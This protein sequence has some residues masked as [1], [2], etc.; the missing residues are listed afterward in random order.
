MGSA[1]RE[2]KPLA[3]GQIVYEKITFPAKA[4]QAPRKER[5]ESRESVV[6]RERGRAKIREVGRNQG[7]MVARIG[8]G[9]CCS[10]TFG[11]CDHV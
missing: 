9:V 11:L 6:D 5:C 8:Q 3:E 7:L 2:M 1:G 10:G 4:G